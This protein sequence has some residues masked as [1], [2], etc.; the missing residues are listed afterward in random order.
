NLDDLDGEVIGRTKD[1]AFKKIWGAHSLQAWGVRLG[2]AKVGT[3]IE[4]WAEWTPQMQARCVSDVVIN[5]AFW[6]FLRPDG[7]SQAALE[8]EHTV[9]AICDRIVSDGVPFDVGAAAQL[10]MDWETKRAALAAPLREQFSTVKNINSRPQLGALLESQGWVPAKRTPK[11]K[12]PVIDDELLES[13]PATYPE[14]AGLAEY[15]VIGRR[16]GQ[17]ATGKQAWIDAVGSD[18]RLH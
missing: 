2:L 5:K 11:T 8:L 9:A 15:F 7:Y 10:R 18:G 3:E 16:L 6:R 13:L 1:K 14:F 17:L 4:I 12:K